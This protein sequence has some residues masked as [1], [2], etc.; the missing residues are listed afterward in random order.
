MKLPQRVAILGAGG[1]IGRKLTTSLLN[2]GCTVKAG[3]RCPAGLND[4]GAVEVVSD[5]TAAE[6][7]DPLIDSVDVLVHAASANTVASSSGHPAREFDSDLRISL[8]MIQAL[9]RKKHLHIIFLSSGGTVY[10]NQKGKKPIRE[11]DLPK[12]QSYHGAAK[13]A[14]ENFLISWA[15]QNS[16]PLTIVRPSNIYGPGQ[17]A[18]TGFGVIPALFRCASQSLPF[19]LRGSLHTVRDFLYIDDFIRLLLFILASG[20]PKQPVIYNAGRGVGTKLE[21]LIK[22]IQYV[23]DSNITTVKGAPLKGE[24]EKVELNCELAEERFG[25]KS[26]TSLETGLSQSWEYWNSTATKLIELNDN[27]I[28]MDRNKDKKKHQE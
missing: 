1:F 25:W 20:Q 15:L 17:S 12:P 11:T 18:R 3:V 22:T 16:S 5:F 28:F 27:H 2:S 26:N 24:I 7:F 23:T 19:R 4:M 13:L 14:V 6:H 21:D 8:A 10:G 9:E